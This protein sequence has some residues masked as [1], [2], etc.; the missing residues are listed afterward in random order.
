MSII[1]KTEKVYSGPE[2][3]VYPQIGTLF[4]GDS[5]TKI[6]DEFGYAYVEYP[7]SNGVKRGY[8]EGYASNQHPATFRAGLLG[9][10]KNVTSVPVASSPDA[11]RITIGSLSAG[12]QVSVLVTNHNNF[13]YVEYGSSSGAKRGWVQ[14][15]FLNLLDNTTLARINTNTQVYATAAVNTSTG[16]VSS[17]E[18]VGIISENE[19]FGK[20]E[21]CM[22]SSPFRKQAFVEMK[23]Y[24][25]FNSGKEIPQIPFCLVVCSFLAIS[26]EEN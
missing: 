11:G 22:A 26:A 17:N 4:A 2:K 14:R 8:I 12:E 18:I 19:Y 21:H 10:V 25:R 16:S 24:T 7:V 20:I 3:N 1:E 5:Y 23:N 6:W 9:I 15:T 13:Y